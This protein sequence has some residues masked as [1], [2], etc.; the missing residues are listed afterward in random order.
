MKKNLLEFISLL[1]SVVLFLVPKYIAPVCMP[2]P[3][4]SHMACFYSGNLIMKFAVFLFIIS[5]SMILASRYFFAKFIKIIGSIANIVIA[6]LVYMVP[7]GIVY[8][9]NEIGKP[10]GICSMHTMECHTH[11]T[12]EIA[13][14][15]AGLIALVMLINLIYIF[16]RKVR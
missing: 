14:I 6:A 15:I 10:Y 5:L 3:D 1:L 2:N 4:G 8:M 16:L 7:H 13:A 11:H 12:F 9:E